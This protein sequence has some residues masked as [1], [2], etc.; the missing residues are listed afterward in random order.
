MSLHKKTLFEGIATALI[1]PFR[2][3]GI[4]YRAMGELIEWQI[5]EGV[6]ALLV[7]GT[8]GECSTLE[9]NEHHDLIAFAK[10]VIR[11]RVPLLAGCGSNATGRA[12]ELTRAACR[13]GADG[14][15]AVTPYYNKASHR[16]LI[17][18]Y[19]AIADA[20][21][22]PLMLYNVPSRTGVSITMEQ[23]RT[24]SEHPNIVGVKEASGDLALLE[25]LVRELGDDL[26]IYT[27][28]D[29]QLLP[30]LKLGAK[31]CISVC[32]NLFPQNTADICRL[33]WKGEAH[34]AGELASRLLPLQNALFA[35]TNPI[36]VKYAMFKKGF[37]DLLYRLPLDAPTDGTRKRIDALL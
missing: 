16:G 31:G 15:L 34:A 37:C 24:L 19:R 3:N 11:G 8:T 20:A 12:I 5:S 36:P 25:R 23:Y 28:N 1:T 14:L 2:E 4:D 27:G 21:T 33:Y 7:A 17:L 26:D 18:H 9:Y 32:A 10:G 29:D 22:R 6:D 13:A 30:A 35:E